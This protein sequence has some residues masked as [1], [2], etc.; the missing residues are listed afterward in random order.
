MRTY[1]HGWVISEVVK[2]LRRQL[3]GLEGG[4]NPL[5]NFARAVDARGSPTLTFTDSEYGRHDPNAQ[6]QHLEAQYPGVV[7]EVSNAQKRK[8]LAIIAEDY[9]LG[10]DGDIR[11]VISLDIEY[12]G[13]KKATLSV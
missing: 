13:S 12:H 9:I 10:S 7:M 8:D 3:R 11:V 6:F 2:D 5:A 4:Q 1:L